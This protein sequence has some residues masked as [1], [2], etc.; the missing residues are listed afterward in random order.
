MELNLHCL[1][2]TEK[3]FYSD[4]RESL[5]AWVCEHTLWSGCHQIVSENFCTKCLHILCINASRQFVDSVT[6]EMA[7]ANR[8]EMSTFNNQIDGIDYY[9]EN[10]L[11]VFTKWHHLKRGYCCKNSCRHCAYGYEK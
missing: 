10:D 4:F 6:I 1:K 7:K 2:C 5:N 8:F 3:I 9:E 11:Y